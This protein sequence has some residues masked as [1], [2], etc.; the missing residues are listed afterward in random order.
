MS[1]GAIYIFQVSQHKAKSWKLKG[2]KKN[3]ARDAEISQ[4][5][6]NAKKSVFRGGDMVH[7]MH[8]C[9]KSAPTHQPLYFQTPPKKSEPWGET[10]RKQFY[11]FKAAYMHVLFGSPSLITII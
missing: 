6:S 1:H 5:D 7:S 10:V 4:R 3:V 11:P 9:N 8:I 2:G